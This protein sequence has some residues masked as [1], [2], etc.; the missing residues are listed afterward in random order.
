MG[1]T[2]NSEVRYLG[3]DPGGRRLGVAVGDD[4][5]GVVTPIG[6]VAFTGISAAAKWI[7]EAAGRHRATVIVVGL[8]AGEDGSVGSA[9]RRTLLLVDAI[10]GHGLEATT[11]NEFLSTDEARRRA[12]A[13]GRPPT[14][15][16][17]DLA[18]QVI[19]EEYF[20]SR[21]REK[22]NGS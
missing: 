16:V 7:V 18:A 9:C 17:D 1:H 22:M 15:P 12:R 11:Q 10:R 5:T 20:S 21:V 6:T 8:P 3:I 19:L 2:Y 14:V 4:Q 13:A